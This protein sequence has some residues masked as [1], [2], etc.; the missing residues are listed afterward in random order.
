MIMANKLS[1]LYKPQRQPENP[2]ETPEISP[3]CKAVKDFR[4]SVYV[5]TAKVT[6]SENAGVVEV[7]ADII[8]AKHGARA[9]GW[10]IDCVDWG[11]DAISMGIIREND[12]SAAH[13]LKVSIFRK[14]ILDLHKMGIDPR[15][16]RGWATW[17]KGFSLSHTLQ[18][19]GL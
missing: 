19:M 12:Y 4:V 13:G 3:W 18:Q 6:E 9:K 8:I 1:D 16:V 11:K 5:H 10:L 2:E 14:M 17:V 7:S 15:E